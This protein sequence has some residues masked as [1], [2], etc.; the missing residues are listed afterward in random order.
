MWAAHRN[1]PATM[2]AAYDS[3]AAAVDCDP[4]A[5]TRSDRSAAVRATHGYGSATMAP[6]SAAADQNCVGCWRD[7]A[8]GI[9]LDVDAVCKIAAGDYEHDGGSK[10]N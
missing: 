3:S 10:R 9:R 8:S 6:A 2:R 1:G 7:D 5:A 4:A